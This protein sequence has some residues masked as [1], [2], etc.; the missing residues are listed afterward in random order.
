MKKHSLSLIILLASCAFMDANAQVGIGTTTP[1]GALDI[2]STTDGL[3][4]PRVALTATDSA[5][6]LTAPT[7]SEM[8]YNTATAGAGATA[9][10]PGYYYWDGTKWVTFTADITKAW[11]LNGNSG[12]AAPSNFL[13]TTDAVDFVTKTNDI[14]RTRITS[15]GNMGINTSLP[16][17]TLGVAGNFSLGNIYSKT[18]PAPANGMRVEGQSVIGKASGEDSRDKLSAH[19]SSTAFVNVAGYP[20]ATAGRALAGYADAG[21]MGVFGYSNGTG[22]GV[23]GLTQNGSISGFV[24]SGE[25]VLGQADGSVATGIP[26]GVHGII[27]ETVAGNNKAVGVI[28]ENNT[29]SV[30]SGFSGGPYG[31]NRAVAG[32]YGNI[33][34]RVTPSS[35]NSYLFGVVGDLLTVGSGTIPDGSGGVLGFGGSGNF[36]MLGYRGLTGTTYSVYGGGNNGSI[37][38]GNSGNRSDENTPNNLV[39]LGINGGFMGGYVK[40]NQYGMVSSGKEFGMYV[41]GNTIV[42][43][44]V[45]QLIDNGAS[46]KTVAYSS[47]STSVDVT[48]RGRATL[49]NGTAFVPFNDAFKNMISKTEPVNVTVTPTGE[50]KGVYIS[51][52]TAEGFYIKENLNGTSN[53]SFNWIAIGT[54]AGF[55]N[56]VEVSSTI[57]SGDFDKNMEGVMNNDGTG[58]EGTPVYF[59]GQK[60]RFERIPEHLL[61]TAKK[62]TKKK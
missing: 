7:T 27:D 35:T 15:A 19:S 49:A 42:N 58:K 62:E 28:G 32:V 50:T 37:N 23:V 13:G 61:P 60:V 18:N 54:R 21:G 48:S 39:G 31:T 20:N 10:S 46:N 34:S 6:P 25:G 14:E 44:P 33:G 55:E 30:G 5:A 45:V 4:I 43:K 24:Q 3:L 2:T 36:G 16:V 26:I 59:D 1:A 41:Q 53:A 11:T 40:G 47:V 17:S 9:V 12:T 8:V 51:E 22:Y 29:I 38:N 52:I 57:L 56:G